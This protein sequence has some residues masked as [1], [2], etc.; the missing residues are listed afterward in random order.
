MP[1]ISAFNGSFYIRLLGVGAASTANYSVTNIDSETDYEQ[2]YSLGYE[3]QMPTPFNVTFTGDGNY[4]YTSGNDLLIQYGPLASPYDITTSMSSTTAI[5][6]GLQGSGWDNIT[7]I[8]FIEPYLDTVSSYQNYSG[9][10]GFYAPYYVH[11]NTIN[12]TDAMQHIPRYHQQTT[13]GAFST[14]STNNSQTIAYHFDDLDLVLPSD[15]DARDIR[16]DIKWLGNQGAYFALFSKSHGTAKGAQLAVW[17]QPGDAYSADS[18]YSYGATAQGNKYVAPGWSNNFVGGKDL[19]VLIN[20]YHSSTDTDFSDFEMN[21]AGTKVWLLSRGTR[22]LYELTLSTPYDP[23]TATYDGTRFAVTM[24]N[25][26]TSLHWVESTESLF[27]GGDGLKVSGSYTSNNGIVEY[28]LTAPPEGLITINWEYATQQGLLTPTADAS[29]APYGAYGAGDS[30]DISDNGNIAIVGAPQTSTSGGSS[31]GSAYIFSRDEEGVWSQDYEFENPDPTPFIFSPYQAGDL[32]GTSVA[33]SGDGNTA[34]VGSTKQENGSNARVGAAHVY[35]KSGSTWTAQ[36]TLQP[37]NLVEN[38]DFGSSVALSQDGN[39]AVVA[40]VYKDASGSTDTVGAVYVFTRSG[41]TWSQEAQLAPAD[42]AVSDYFGDSIAIS[43]DGNILVAGSRSE[44]PSG[45]TDA[46]SAYVF[47]RSGSTWTEQQKIQASDATASDRFGSY[48]SMSGDGSTI[49]IG[50]RYHA[51]SGLTSG[52]AVYVFTESGGTWTEQQK[53]LSDEIA[54]QDAFCIP[55]LSEDGNTLIVGAFGANSSITNGGAAYVFTRSGSTWTQVKKLTAKDS[56]PSDNFGWSTAISSDGTTAIVG[57]NETSNGPG[58]AYTFDSTAEQFVPV[59]TTIALSSFSGSLPGT[60]YPHGV[61][62]NNDGTKAY[63]DDMEISG[64][65]SF[66]V[67][68]YSLSTPYDLATA[69]YTTRKLASY[70]NLTDTGSTTW[71]SDGSKIYIGAEMQ[72]GTTDR[73]R[74]VEFNVSTPFDIS[75]MSTTPNTYINST[76]YTKSL[77]WNEDGTKLFAAIDSTG[78]LTVTCSTPYSLSGATTAFTQLFDASTFDIEGRAWG[79]AFRNNGTE[80]FILQSQV[81]DDSIWKFSLGTAYD[82][83]TATLIDTLTTTDYGIDYPKSLTYAD[84]KL[85]IYGNADVGGSNVDAYTYLDSTIIG[86]ELVPTFVW[87]GD[88][89]VF[90]GGTNTI[91]YIDIT[92]P[93]NATD[94]GDLLGSKSNLGAASNSTRGVFFGG[95]G[96]VDI[97]YITVSTPS[98]ALDFG[99]LTQARSNV[100]SLSDGTYGLTGGGI[101]SNTGQT[102]IDYVVMDTTGNALDFA[103]LTQG[104]W[105]LAT[106]N[107]DTYGL[108]AGGSADFSTKSNTIDYV[109]IA[110]TSNAL[111][112]GDLTVARDQ[113]TGTSDANY[114]IF[115]GG[116]DGNSTLHNTIDYVTTATPSNASDFGDMTTAL[117]QPSACSNGTYGVIGGG[118]DSYPA[119]VNIIQYFTIATPSNAS[120]FGDLTQLRGGLA[121]LSGAAA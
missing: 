49:A 98:N 64:S 65:T 43:N 33:I 93:G 117:Y 59:Y 32:F 20:N 63:L 86:A 51:P 57:A 69:T 54:A 94:F 72:S 121:A 24:I 66:S 120:D 79:V 74:I 34:I 90:G 113:L 56:Q 92:S 81:T 1:I 7:N 5:T 103:D 52:G 44:D 9:G 50:A 114:S 13:P 17:S 96:T 12:L 46:G 104:R 116:Y 105:S 55:S 22:W 109:T 4:M 84:G 31:V 30:V 37:S 47:T 73:P 87:G 83:T 48:A 39:T 85:I 91:D 58:M 106:G 2:L 100:S 15:V 23:T 78:I 3:S 115:A 107:S 41:S 102:T 82:F 76:N 8:G 62:F 112:F 18:F 118:V 19:A 6:W 21:D 36:T 110:T 35:T 101:T 77:T 89:G 53:I 45:I 95:N 28:S 108:F 99:D 26:P 42:L 11:P 71:N 10:H 27:I 119:T 88:R 70:P 80:M 68:E 75:T 60:F 14:Q 16:G 97:N 29:Y 40:A 111:D 25:I 67:A 38:D 61:S